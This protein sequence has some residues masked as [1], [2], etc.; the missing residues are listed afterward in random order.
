MR[1][2]IGTAP[3][4]PVGFDFYVDIVPAPDVPADKM[5]VADLN[6]RWPFSDEQVVFVRA[7]D[8]IEHLRDQIHTMNELW[9]VLKPGGIAD[10][11]VPTTEGPGAFKDPTHRSFWTRLS[12]NYYEKGHPDRE[13]FARNYGIVAAFK[14]LSEKTVRT[15]EGPRLEIVLQA[16]K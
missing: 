9:R 5:I 8:I 15:P 1:I 7:F 13:R 11:A 4:A 2:D 16:V 6:H 12:F 3:G 14:I 10:I